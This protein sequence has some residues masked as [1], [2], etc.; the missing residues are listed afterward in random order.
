M[1]KSINNLRLSQWI[2]CYFQPFSE[3]AVQRKMLVVG[4]IILLFGYFNGSIAYVEQ[5]TLYTYAC[6][7]LRYLICRS[8][9]DWELVSNSYEMWAIRM[10]NKLAEELNVSVAL[11]ID[12]TLVK[13]DIRSKKLAVGGK[14]DKKSGFSFLTGVLVIEHITIPLVPQLCFRKVFSED[15]ELEYVSKVEKARI[16]LERWIG[17]GLNVKKSVVIMDSWYSSNAM[18]NYCQSI[19]ALKYVLGIKLNRNLDKRPVSK[20]RHGF[21][22][23]KSKKANNKDYD[24][25]LYLRQG[26]LKEVKGKVNV[27]FSKRVNTKTQDA[28]WRYF[29]TNIDKELTVLEWVKTR[30]QIET[31]HQIFKYRFKPENWRVHGVER[32]THMTILVTMVMGY[33]VKYFLDKNVAYK[34]SMERLL[35]HNIMSESLQT[36]RVILIS[37]ETMIKNFIQQG[38]S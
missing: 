8:K 4:C 22:Y 34:Y 10:A 35:K 1:L 6:D 30:W 16:S 33:A 27:L 28:S 37:N 36:F 17:M 5:C 12:D 13:K 32:L 20:L 9:I 29:V 14:R 15:W 2:Y 21:R 11:I 38:D 24:F 19:P 7:R 25:F 18:I 23:Y 3:K 31:F 26:T